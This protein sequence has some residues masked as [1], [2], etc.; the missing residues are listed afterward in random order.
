MRIDDSS[1]RVNRHTC[2][3]CG[4]CVDRCIMDNLRLSVAPC[5]QVCP[6]GMNCQGYIRLI[7]MDKEV[8]ALDQLLPFGPFLGVI[9][10]TCNAP[11]ETVCVRKKRDG[12]V[13]I[14]ELE[15]YMAKK[16][17][18]K[19]N[20][21]EIPQV[22]SGKSV[23]IVGTGISGLACGFRAIQSGHSVTL[24][25]RSSDENGKTGVIKDIIT[26]LEN[27]GAVFLKHTDLKDSFADLKNFD[28]VILSQLKDKLLIASDYLKIASDTEIDSTSHLL[29]DNI[30]CSDTGSSKKGSIYEIA[31]S[32]ETIESVNRFFNNEPFDWGRGFYTQGGAVK[33]YKADPR[34][35]SEEQRI[36]IEDLPYGFDK[37]TAKK[38][39][40][41]CFG[42]GRAFEKNQT[43]WYCLPCELEC[44]QGALDVT[45]PYL[46]K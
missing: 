30:F 24:Y 9:A 17:S 33:T 15:R 23:V 19:L 41:R 5:R 44:P 21:V 42:C 20:T 40:S 22:L 3:A 36:A 16:Y 37:E 10:A 32:F 1:I 39:A 29:Q 18:D 8:L 4:I 43:C 25:S 12:A 11:C 7:A 38:Q 27:A 45:I 2:I 46:V 26:A 35:G 6:V 28:A 34:V 13:H 14:F 31:E